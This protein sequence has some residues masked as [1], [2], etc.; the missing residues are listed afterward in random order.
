MSI[1]AQSGREAA[2]PDYMVPFAPILQKGEK[3]F[4]MFVDLKNKYDWV[5][6]RVIVY[7]SVDRLIEVLEDEIVRP[8]EAKF[9]KLLAR[10]DQTTSP[11]EYLEPLIRTRPVLRL[12]HSITSSARASSV[13]GTSTPSA[14]AVGRLMTNS[15]LLDC[16]TGRSAGLAPLRILPV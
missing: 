9:N 2:V 11:Q 16:T 5:L 4:A 13:G 7:P 6:K 12:L 8:S 3:P 15:N 10:A 14:R 1:L